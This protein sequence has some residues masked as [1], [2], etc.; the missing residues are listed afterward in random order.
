MMGREPLV[1]QPSAET[2]AKTVLVVD[3]EPLVGFMVESI[4][5]DEGFEVLYASN[6]D[7]ALEVLQNHESIVAIVT[8]IDM[9]GMSGLELAAAVRRARPD[10]GIV[11]MS[12]G[13]MPDPAAMQ[14]RMAYLA[15]P[16]TPTQ[17]VTLVRD[18]TA[19]A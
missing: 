6:G 11:L 2:N 18:L 19:P 17:I 7:D 3:D 10:L 5:S 13:V 8:D 4:L 12:G 14:C 16:C 1:S 15:K 9:P